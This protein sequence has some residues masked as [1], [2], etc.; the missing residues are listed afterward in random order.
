MQKRKQHMATDFSDINAG[1]IELYSDTLIYSYFP[2]AVTPQEAL[3]RLAASSSQPYLEPGMEFRVSRQRPNTALWD[4][5][6]V[7]KIWYLGI[8]Q[9]QIA[10]TTDSATATWLAEYSRSAGTGWLD[11]TY[12]SVQPNARIWFQTSSA[13]FPRLFLKSQES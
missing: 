13:G 8:Y 2:G 11:R 10:V 5:K 9:E 6:E 7:G 12:S 3:A 4:V 1:G